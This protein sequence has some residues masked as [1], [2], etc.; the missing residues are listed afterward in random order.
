[1]KLNNLLSCL[2]YSM[3][4]VFFGISLKNAYAAEVTVWVL[5]ERNNEGVLSSITLAVKN[6]DQIL[7][8]QTGVCGFL[9]FTYD[10]QLG[11]RIYADPKD[12]C[13]YKSD[14]RCNKIVLLRVSRRAGFAPCIKSTRFLSVEFSDG[15]KKDYTIK[16][17]GYPHHVRYKNDVTSPLPK[18]TL[19][20][21][22]PTAHITLHLERTIEEFNAPLSLSITE[23]GSKRNV[24][25]LIISGFRIYKHEIPRSF[26]GLGRDNRRVYSEYAREIET[27]LIQKIKLDHQKIQRAMEKQHDIVDNKLKT[28]DEMKGQ[29]KKF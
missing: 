23:R 5:D 28:C 20:N 24:K 18:F 22:E 21:P 17:K 16:W 6:K 8:D 3:F 9:R 13:F 4:I 25:N 19:L 12:D 26:R 2:F 10:C 29:N 15:A 1:M 7:I 11:D 14:E 27:I